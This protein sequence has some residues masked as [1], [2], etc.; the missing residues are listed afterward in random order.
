VLSESKTEGIIGDKIVL[1][2]GDWNYEYYIKNSLFENEIV[3]INPDSDEVLNPLYGDYLMATF[4]QGSNLC[5]EATVDFTYD[6]TT[7]K[8][9]GVK[10]V[11]NS[12]QYLDLFIISPLEYSRRINPGDNFTK[13][14]TTLERPSYALTDVVKVWGIAKIIS[15][16]EWRC[17]LGV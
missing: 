7:M 5:G 1:S 12:T 8:M 10:L 16:I 15:G 2:D 6:D 11:N 4:T 9:T 17:C 14:L 13:N 3:I